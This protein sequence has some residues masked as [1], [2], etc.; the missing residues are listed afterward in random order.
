MSETKGTAGKLMKRRWHTAHFKLV[1][2][3]LEPLPDALSLK[4][5]ARQ[6]L[7]DGD[8]LAKDW[9]DCKKGV[10]NQE[11]SSTN[12]IRVTAEKLATKTARKKSKTGSKTTTT[13][14]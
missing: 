5:F 9:F 10:L 11:R 14:A 6:L 8:P 12:K 13:A 7:K 2:K 4:A 3:E 1:N